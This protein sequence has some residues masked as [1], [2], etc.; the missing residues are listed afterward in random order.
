MTAH[1]RKISKGNEVQ[2]LTNPSIKQL[3]NMTD[4]FNNKLKF[5]KL[6]KK[7]VVNN[8]NNTILP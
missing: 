6:A 1:Y 8:Y 5:D 4:Q 7:L 3:V 2:Q